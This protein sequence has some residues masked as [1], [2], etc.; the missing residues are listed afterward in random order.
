MVDLPR[1]RLASHPWLSGGGAGDVQA[2]IESAAA[3]TLHSI[4]AEP[5]TGAVTREDDVYMIG[6]GA[7]TRHRIPED[8]RR[9]LVQ[10]DVNR[11]WIIDRPERVASARG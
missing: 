6:S 8:L 1:A 10:G 11:D 9:P 7:L 4:G 5:G 3:S 2:A